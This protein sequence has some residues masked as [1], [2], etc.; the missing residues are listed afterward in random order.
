MDPVE[1]HP[2]L[3]PHDYSTATN[4]TCPTGHLP[5]HLPTHPNSQARRNN[6]LELLRR[7]HLVS[8]TRAASRHMLHHAVM[9]MAN[10]KLAS[11]LAGW[12]EA[13]VARRTKKELLRV[14]PVSPTIVQ[15]KREMI[16]VLV[17]AG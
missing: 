13:A 5:T 15:P 14:R 9:R 3:H 1:G 7:W 17:Y 2:P 10:S 11:A 12:R 8:A 6:L 4:P 16:H